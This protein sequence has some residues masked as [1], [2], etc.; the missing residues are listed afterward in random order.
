MP[1]S[2][3]WRS[4]AGRNAVFSRPNKLRRLRLLRDL[5]RAGDHLH[6]EEGA[7]Q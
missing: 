3:Q 5:L 2:V 7:D 1:N 4:M 6:Q